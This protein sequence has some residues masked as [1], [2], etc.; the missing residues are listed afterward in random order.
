MIY[1]TTRLLGR[2]VRLIR[3]DDEI[4][5]EVKRWFGWNIV[6]FKHCGYAGCF[7]EHVTFKTFDEARNWV[8]AIREAEAGTVEER[9][10]AVA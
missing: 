5:V 7:T 10:C 8:K 3:N 9:E 6:K 4:H 2:E 1:P